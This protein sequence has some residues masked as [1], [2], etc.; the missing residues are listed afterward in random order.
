MLQWSI[1]L[2][3]PFTFLYLFSLMTLYIFFNNWKE[4]G[5][6]SIFIYIYIYFTYCVLFYCFYVLLYCFLC[7][8]K[9]FTKQRESFR[10]I[11][12]AMNPFMFFFFFRMSAF[13]PSVCVASLYRGSTVV[14]FQHLDSYVLPLS[15]FHDLCSEIWYW[16][17]CVSTK[18]EFT[19]LALLPGYFIFCFQIFN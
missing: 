12:L 8:L 17:N 15:G 19:S 7:A 10:V 18:G 1:E 16:C 11:Q 4:I 14:F 2:L 3:S 9:K 6:N 5:N 13:C